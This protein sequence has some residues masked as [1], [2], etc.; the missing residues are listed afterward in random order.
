MKIIMSLF[1]LFLGL[2]L[3]AIFFIYRTEMPTSGEL[4]LKNLKSKVEVYRDDYGV[5]HIQASNNEDAYRALGFLQASD[6]LFQMELLRRIGSGS[7]SELL[8]PD[9]LKTDL[10]LR[11][12][13]LRK[14]A[15]EIIKRSK[16][17][18]PKE[19]QR[20]TKAFM[21]GV[22]EFVATMPL[23]IEFIILGTRPA[24][25]TIEDSIAI[26]GYM[27]LS[28]AEGLLVDPLFSD[29]KDEIS[30]KKLEELFIETK[31]DKNSILP[32]IKTS[33][34]KNM[35]EA[36]IPLEQNFGLFHGSN[37][38]VISGNR[39]KSGK[40]LLCNDPH[41]AFSLPGI[42][43][44]AHIKTP[45]ME[46]YGHYVP[47]SPYTP[48]G[49][50]Q[51][52]GWAVTM[53]EVDDL[54]LYYE[55]LEGDKVYYKNKL[56]DL[57]IE[58]EVIKIKGEKD[59]HFKLRS[60]AHGPILNNT[61]FAK[62]GENLAIK[63]SFH[64][65]KND[66]VRALYLLSKAKN[67]NDFFKAVSYG[68]APAL[69][70][71][72]ADASGNIAWKIM[73]LIPIR[74]KG[75]NSKEVLEGWSGK[76]DYLGYMNQEDNPSL[77]NPKEGYIASANYAPIYKGDHPMPGYYQPSERYERIVKLIEAKDKW[78][79]NDMKKIQ[80]DQVVATANWMVPILLNQ[81]NS[82]S[83]A[84]RYLKNWQ[85]QSD[86]ESIPSSL[87]HLWC[88]HIL[89][90]LVIDELGE[91]RYANFSRTADSW[92]FF[93]A[94]LK[95]SDS[96]WWDN[97]KTSEVETMSKIV[98]LSLKQS[99]SFLEKTFGDDPEKWSWGNVHT[100]EYPHPF[101]K[102]KPLDK[103]FNRGPFKAGGGFFQI[104]NMSNS[105]ADFSFSVSLGPSVRRLVDFKNPKE[106]LS[107]LPAG[108]SGNPISKFYDDQ[109]EMFLEK[110]YRE[111]TMDWNKIIKDRAPLT[112]IP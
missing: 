57:K 109:I 54:D 6:R 19:L 86:I 55:K 47:L 99:I 97:T 96:P 72:W 8:G 71:S 89:K 103:I 4:K 87:Y 84:S 50:N 24:P 83:I 65:E 5:P 80:T 23:P 105:R 112:L 106:A 78:S 43:Y 7:L 68:A 28:F 26:S 14:T 15:S 81:V 76:H 10:L 25:F 90:N 61:Q 45:E 59:H 29:L 39:S 36:L 64:H 33:Y 52:V 77:L 58:E 107:I 100:L 70:L 3:S 110:D 46:L 40:P 11:S 44:E 79:L 111:A 85:G 41:V 32:R 73:G 88:V 35:R 66:T 9:L 48:M 92:N 104:D 74:P 38:W 42:W 82:P 60:T 91:A 13:R 21:E 108:N 69:N 34:Q 37:S 51:E 102:K 75:T 22:N 1:I 93:K 18:W 20:E 49:H 98:E 63:W 30:P 101:G 31:A 94:V 53:A 62:E 27:A 16:S 56:V 67:V 12:L 2:S 95:N 17:T